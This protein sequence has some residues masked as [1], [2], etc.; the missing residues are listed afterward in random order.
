MMSW[1]SVTV[2]DTQEGSFWEGTCACFNLWFECPQ[3]D[4]AVL[5]VWQLSAEQVQRG[6]HT[7]EE[8]GP[9]TPEV[10]L[11]LMRTALQGTTPKTRAGYHPKTS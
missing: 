1:F 6:G 4:G 10:A 3:S 9:S 5:L 7:G 11:P 2:T 8:V